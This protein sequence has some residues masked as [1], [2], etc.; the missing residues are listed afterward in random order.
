MDHGSELEAQY[1]AEGLRVVGSEDG[2]EFFTFPRELADEEFAP[3]IQRLA[4]LPSSIGFSEMMRRLQHD[5]P[6]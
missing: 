5:A 1:W 3:M 2:T 6:E 4:A